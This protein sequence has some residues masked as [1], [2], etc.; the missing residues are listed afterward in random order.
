[1]VKNLDLKHLRAG[2]LD[3]GYFEPGP[4]EGLPTIL[5]YG[6]PTMPMLMKR[7]RAI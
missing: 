6:S 7:S 4:A 5:L 3:I 1:M 2:V